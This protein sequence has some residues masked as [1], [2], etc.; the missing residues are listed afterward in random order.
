M[1]EWLSLRTQNRWILHFLFFLML[2]P[3]VI[4][5]GLVF[6]TQIREHFRE[7]VQERLNVDQNLARRVR[8]LEAQVSHLQIQLNEQVLQLETVPVSVSDASSIADYLDAQE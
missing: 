5:V 3:I 6:R 1:M 7:F 2:I 4:L 8:D